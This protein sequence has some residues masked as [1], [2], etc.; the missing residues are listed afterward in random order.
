MGAAVVG[1]T[2]YIV[3]V[4]MLD[5]FATRVT[6]DGARSSP[7]RVLRGTGSNRSRRA[8]FVWGLVMSDRAK[9]ERCTWWERGEVYPSSG[10][11]RV[12]SKHPRYGWP[13]TYPDDWCGEFSYAEPVE[14]DE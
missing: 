10:E 4:R 8:P 14:Q 1:Q 12:R 3:S 5:P 13:T 7:V 11:C 2:C 6:E 9:C